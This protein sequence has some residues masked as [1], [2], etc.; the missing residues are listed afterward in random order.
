MKL[1][2]FAQLPIKIKTEDELIDEE[3][4]RLREQRVRYASF[5]KEK[6]AQHA[7]KESRRNFEQY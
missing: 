5:K 6:V 1:T 4:N 3:L 2:S 7:L